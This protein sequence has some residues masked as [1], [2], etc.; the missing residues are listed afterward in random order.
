[1]ATVT[2]QNI[3]FSLNRKFNYVKLL[4]IVFIE[5][6]YFMTTFSGKISVVKRECPGLFPT[7]LNIKSLGPSEYISM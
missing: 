3:L 1:M 5:L 7:T 6:R 4:S 2:L